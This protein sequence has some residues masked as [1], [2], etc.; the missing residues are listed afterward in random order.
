MRSDELY[1]W[2]ILGMK[3][4][5]RRFQNE[6]GSLTP[7]GRERYLGKSRNGS[8]TF[9]NNGER[10]I[11]KSIE[12]KYGS[13]EAGILNDPS[14][15]NSYARVINDPVLKQ[16]ILKDNGGSLPKIYDLN[17]SYINMVFKTYYKMLDSYFYGTDYER[18]YSDA[19]LTKSEWDAYT[20]RFVDLMYGMDYAEESWYNMRNF[21]TTTKKAYM[22]LINDAAKEN[23]M[24]DYTD[25]LPKS[26]DTLEKWPDRWATGASPVEGMANH[27][28]DDL[29]FFK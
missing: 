23:G 4:G 1:H 24:G 16:A 6:D 9:T 26:L 20:E 2:G 14:V 10:L 15:K 17:L 12:K 18:Y 21:V 27:K 22:N 25:K 29:L 11:T 7:E 13:V 5:V 3:W 28:W 19:G 8:E